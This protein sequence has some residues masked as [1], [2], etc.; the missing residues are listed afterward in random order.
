MARVV[1]GAADESAGAGGEPGDSF[2][3]GEHADCAGGGDACA[4]GGAEQ[5]GADRAGGKCA[6]F[7]ARHRRGS[8]PTNVRTT[9]VVQARD[10][11]ASISRKFNVKLESLAAANPGVDPRKIH[12]GQVLNVPVNEFRRV[13]AADAMALK[14]DFWHYGR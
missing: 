6:R 9:Y 2:G 11:L 3:A 4:A 7:T 1:C 14:E 8:S 10:T 12:P 13:A 5:C